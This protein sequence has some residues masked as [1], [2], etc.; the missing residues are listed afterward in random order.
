M[1]QTALVRE[2]ISGTQTSVPL[3][4]AKQKK[5]IARLDT[6]PHTRQ[7][8]LTRDTAWD[9]WRDPLASWMQRDTRP[10][11]LAGCFGRIH[12]RATLAG[13]SPGSTGEL[14][15][16]MPGG[17]LATLGYSAG[18]SAGSI[19]LASS[20]GRDPQLAACSALAASTN[21]PLWR[22]TWIFGRKLLWRDTG[23][24]RGVEASQTRITHNTKYMKSN[25]PTPSCRVG[26]KKWR[27]GRLLIPM[28][29]LDGS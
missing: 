24:G 27:N 28:G 25:L 29:R 13:C 16:G 5:N 14:F 8:P 18:Y 4:K 9:T 11:P 15:C 3:T 2:P 7:D 22:D 17:I 10:D 1:S 23:W 19:A 12:W 26:N 6:C 21:E 20:S